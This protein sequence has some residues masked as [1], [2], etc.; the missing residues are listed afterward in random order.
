MHQT[1]TFNAGGAII[2]LKINPRCAESAAP[3]FPGDIRRVGA[4]QRVQRW[5]LFNENYLNTER[6]GEINICTNYTAAAAMFRL[7]MREGAFLCG[8]CVSRPAECVLFALAAAAV[9]LIFRQPHSTQRRLCFQ[10]HS[11]LP[12]WLTKDPQA[13]FPTNLVLRAAHSAGITEIC[14]RDASLSLCRFKNLK[15]TLAMSAQ[16]FFSLAERRLSARLATLLLF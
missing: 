7:K 8:V 15:C 12:W 3:L 2:H 11:R 16:R 1:E 5:K 14:C 10:K 13:L 6:A 9:F 4:T